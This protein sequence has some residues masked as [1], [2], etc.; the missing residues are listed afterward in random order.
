MNLYKKTLSL[1]VVNLLFSTN[2]LSKKKQI[3]KKAL[4]TVSGVLISFFLFGQLPTYTVDPEF[5]SGELFKASASVTDF[6]FLENNQVLVVG[7]FSN[8][9]VSGF[10][11]L[12]ENGNWDDS[13]GYPYEPAV[14]E[15]IIQEDGYIYPFI[16]GFSKVTLDGTPWIIEYGE[17]FSDYIGSGTN[18]PYNVER[19]WDID[20]LENGDILIGG[21]IATDTLQPGLLRGITRMHADGSHDSTFPILN[22]TPNNG[23]GAVREI[24]SAPDGSWYISG[25]FTAINGHETNHV[26]KLTSDFQVDPNFVSPFMYD[27]PVNYTEDIMLVDSQSRIWVSGYDMRLQENPNDTIQIIRLLPDGS[28]DESFLP[29]KLENNYPDD[30]QFLPSLA[31]YA[32]ELINHPGNYIIYGSFSHFNE[33]AQPCITVVNDQG[34]I[35]EHFL[36]NQGATHHLDDNEVLRMPHVYVVDQLENGQLL[37]G[38]GFSE[39]MGAERYSLVRLEPGFLSTEQNNAK[40]HF[41]LYPNP[42]KDQVTIQTIENWVV[43]NTTVQIRDTSGRLVKSQ[44]LSNQNID[45]SGLNPGF[46]LVQIFDSGKLL[47]MAKLVV[48]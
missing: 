32:Q 31:Y 1:K 9:M 46:Y 8:E 30:W 25:S 23:G 13:W 33:I 38:G 3:Q 27:G 22:I 11:M 20:Q 42:A 16:Y 29:R 15:I 28:V 10:A 41:K 19:V 43:A 5:D 40:D 36:Q 18:N 39:F 26:A 4:L 48:E 14:N 47:G 37:I 24:F 17:H 35:Q 45:V 2:T 44:T 12:F 6:H 7:T 21:A 34:E